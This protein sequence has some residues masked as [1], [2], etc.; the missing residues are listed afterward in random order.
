MHIS[1]S[2]Y[3]HGEWDCREG[4][5]LYI[6]KEKFVIQGSHC[7]INRCIN[8]VKQVSDSSVL[9]HRRLGHAPLKIIRK[10]ENLEH[11][12]HEDQICTVCPLAK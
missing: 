2:L 8:T 7:E 1:V 4:H 6:L 10:N 5:G 11:L 3:W 12:K 9:W